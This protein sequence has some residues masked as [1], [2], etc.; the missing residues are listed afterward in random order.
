ALMFARSICEATG[1]DLAAVG[2]DGR[3]GQCP[4]VAGEIG[5][6]AIR[7]GDTV[8]EHAVHFGS[9]G[10]TVSLCHSAHTRDTFAAGALRAAAWVVGKPAGKYEMADVLFGDQQK[11]TKTSAQP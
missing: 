7:L 10:E 1:K 8:G 4:R 6:H 9:L 11:K 3:S 5:M 2:R